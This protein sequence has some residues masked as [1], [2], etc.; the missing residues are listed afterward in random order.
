M[1]DKFAYIKTMWYI[2]PIIQNKSWQNNP[3]DIGVKIHQQHS[4]K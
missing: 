4:K 2:C 1:Q 3:K